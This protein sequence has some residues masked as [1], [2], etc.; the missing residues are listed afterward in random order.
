MTGNNLSGS[1]LDFGVSNIH[2]Q[3]GGESDTSGMMHSKI[4]TFDASPIIDRSS[5]LKYRWPE[6]GLKTNS[7]L[8][9]A[10]HDVSDITDAHALHN[11]YLEKSNTDQST[12]I[13]LEKNKRE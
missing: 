12:S 5:A 11:N 7:R 13:L 3:K 10:M 1:N 4:D 2:R 9:G 6:T 8:S